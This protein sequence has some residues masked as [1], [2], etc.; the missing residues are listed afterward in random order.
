MTL[1]AIHT[2]TAAAA[3]SDHAAGSVVCA[4][5]R[6]GNAQPQRR[7]NESR[8]GSL[9]AVRPAVRPPRSLHALVSRP[10]RCSTT[11]ALT[12][13]DGLRA[14]CV[15]ASTLWA[16]PQ[17][18]GDRTKRKT[19]ESPPVTQATAVDH[20]NRTF[21]DMFLRWVLCEQW[22]G[23]DVWATPREGASRTPCR[24]CVLPPCR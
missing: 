8:G 17:T 16:A 22:R 14:R 23:G 2:T 20:F 5:A 3:S 7:K 4:A 19:M 13:H 21:R 15:G 24:A 9:P 1:S 11:H 12:P 18:A 6:S 10:E